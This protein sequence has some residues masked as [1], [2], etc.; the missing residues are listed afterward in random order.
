M[1][2]PAGMFY[3]EDTMSAFLPPASGANDEQVAEGQATSDSE[4]RRV[5]PLIGGP[6]GPS[7]R[8]ERMVIILPINPIRIT[9]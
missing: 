2:H 7:D 9:L 8:R 3:S 4:E 5:N 6:E 1:D